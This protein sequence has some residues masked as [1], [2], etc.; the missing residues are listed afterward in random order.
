LF[1]AKD[2]DLTVSAEGETASSGNER[3]GRIVRREQ[4]VRIDAIANI[5]NKLKVKYRGK[6]DIVGGVHA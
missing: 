3:K 4:R 1:K 2:Y 5:M 6:K